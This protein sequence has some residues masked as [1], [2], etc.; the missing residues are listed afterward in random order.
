[1]GHEEH[2]IS[3]QEFIDNVGKKMADKDFISDMNG[4]LRTGREYNV[5]QAYQFINESLWE[6]I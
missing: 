4:L 3:K 2:S 5:E 6:K 1:M